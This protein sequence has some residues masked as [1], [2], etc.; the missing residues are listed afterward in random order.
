MVSLLDYVRANHPDEP[1][2]NPGVLQ[3]KKSGGG[4]DADEVEDE[5]E[6]EEEEEEDKE[7]DAPS[8]FPKHWG[9]EPMIQTRDYRELP[10]GYG[11][12]SGT[13][14]R[15]IQDNLDKDKAAA[16]AAADAPT[17]GTGDL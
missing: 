7:D 2:E 9:D 4:D 1:W 12:G 6:E 8:R 5:Q 13:L 14:A 17:S 3:T 11:M 10:G 15:W 16:D